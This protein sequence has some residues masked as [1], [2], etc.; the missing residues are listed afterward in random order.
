MVEP[1]EPG[2]N[3]QEPENRRGTCI[4]DCRNRSEVGKCDDCGDN[5]KHYK[6]VEETPEELRKAAFE[7]DPESF[8]HLEDCLLV[9]AC[10]RDEKGKIVSYGMHGTIRTEDEA[11]IARGRA[12]MIVDTCLAQILQK[13]AQAAKKGIQIAPAGAMHGI[14]NRIKGAFGGGR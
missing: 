11:H 10:Q 3:G 9:I 2:N 1:T 5:E 13:R 8:V 6:K 12:S 4:L 14:K 7:K